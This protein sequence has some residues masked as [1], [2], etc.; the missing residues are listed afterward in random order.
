MSSRPLL[1]LDVDGVLNPYPETPPGYAEYRFFP[2][3]D[4]PVR[5]CTD[6]GGWLL[7]LAAVYEIAWASGWGEAANEL[8]CPVLGLPR[9]TVV[10]LPPRPFDPTLKLPAVTAFAGDR[11]A[12]WVDDIV[13]EEMCAWA[14]SRPAPT[15]LIEIPSASGLTRDVVDRL[16][17]WPIVPE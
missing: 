2:Q 3:D 9:F 8:V 17:A 4:E 1:L 11:A 6:H 13:T 16:L 12:A 10:T 15:L 7:E 5:L 14:A